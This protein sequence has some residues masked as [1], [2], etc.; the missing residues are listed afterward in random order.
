VNTVILI[1]RVI[2]QKRY[3]FT[4]ITDVREHVVLVVY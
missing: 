3:H 1:I 4:G 2:L